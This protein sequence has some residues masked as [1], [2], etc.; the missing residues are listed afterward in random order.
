MYGADIISVLNKAIDNNVTYKADPSQGNFEPQLADFYVNIV[1]TY[2]GNTYSLKDNLGN[3]KTNFLDKV[4][5]RNDE[6]MYKFKSAIFRCTG[7][8][9]NG[10]T[11]LSNASAAG[12]VRQMTFSVIR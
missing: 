1:F 2:G 8:E 11:G 5:D 9:Y 3:I 12:R 6:E 4:T 10:Q 7:V